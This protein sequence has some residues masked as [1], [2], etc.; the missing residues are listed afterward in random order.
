[1]IAS[2]R[3]LVTVHT[4]A[5]GTKGAGGVLQDKWFAIRMPHRYRHR[6]I[7]FKEFY[8]IIYSIL[9]WGDEF[10]GSH[11][12]FYTDNT[13]VHAALSNLTIR[14]EPMME[15]LRQFLGLACRFDFTFESRWIPSGD[16]SLADAASRFQY[17][18]LFD[19]APY[20]QRKPSPKRHHVDT[21]LP[22]GPR[23]SIT[24]H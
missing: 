13:D 16:N 2:D 22:A 1:M 5:S 6:D 3:P 17:Q 12:L 7:K 9:C 24:L 4:D 19:L 23:P 20:L 14:S 15:L 8:A 21:S 18:R 10:K 11:V